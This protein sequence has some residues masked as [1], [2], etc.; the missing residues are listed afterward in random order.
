MTLSISFENGIKYTNLDFM[1]RDKDFFGNGVVNPATSQFPLTYNGNMTLSVGAGVAWVD[2][3]RIA[4]DSNL[5]TLTVAAANPTNPRI[6]IVQIGHDDV[7]STYSLIVKQGVAAAT[8]TEPGADTNY[9]KLYAINVAANA[10]SIT[11]ANVTDRRALLPLNVNGSQIVQSG[12]AGTGAN[13]FTGTQTAPEFV[14]T[15]TTTPL[16]M[17]A[18]TAVPGVTAPS[19]TLAVVNNQW[20]GSNGS[21][22]NPMNVPWSALTGIPTDFAKTDM[23]QTWTAVQTWSASQTFP[24]TGLSGVPT[25]FAKIDAAQTWT[26]P[27]TFAASQTFAWSGVSG[28][29]ST[30]SGYG[31]T[32]DSPTW[33][34]THTF[35]NPISG[36]VTGSAGAVPWS[37]VSSKPTT[38]SGYG[39]AGDSPTWTGAHTFNNTITGNVSGSAG[40][41]AWSG[42]SGKPTTVSGYGI[43]GDSPTWTGTH[44]FN[45]PISGS[46]TGGAGSVPWSGITSKPT[47]A[48]GYG[49]TLPKVV[50]IP[51]WNNDATAVGSSSSASAGIVFLGLGNGGSSSATSTQA[52]LHTLDSWSTATAFAFEAFIYVSNASATG[53]AA[54]WDFSANG[55][56]GAIVAGTTIQTSSTLSSAVLMRTSQVNLTA[57]H[58]YGV[59]LWTGGGTYV[60]DVTHANLVAFPQ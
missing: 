24:W 53:Y 13:T 10:T 25:D 60:A 38:V 30:A 39:V 34:G 40:S 5:V 26:Q 45:N 50:Y 51:L 32:G 35:S 1:N 21:A 2:G 11:S 47:T 54:L 4:N 46:V 19:G 20:Y 41:V 57:G 59:T 58:V 48:A 31:I 44:T 17:P 33:T 43:A 18:L 6:D 7:N 42:V 56:A 37:G 28:K 16:Q 12:S 22:W 8:P 29:P 14:A 55:G 15:S 36:S 27:Q 9:I 3:Y 49:I 23:A 52:K